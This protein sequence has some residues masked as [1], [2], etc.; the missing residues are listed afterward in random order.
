MEVDY[1]DINMN[2]KIK[3]FKTMKDP[4]IV[5]VGDKEAAEGTVAITVRGQKQQLHNVPL[6]TLVKMCN[7][8]NDE[9]SL[10]LIGETPM[11]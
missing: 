2:T 3:N 6:E 8:M 5:V 9:H 1:A 4:Y 10:E 7:K 11:D